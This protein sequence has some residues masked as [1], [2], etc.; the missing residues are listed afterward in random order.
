MLHRAGQVLVPELGGCTNALPDAHTGLMRQIAG[1][2]RGM[3]L[4]TLAA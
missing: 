2:R 1:R 4:T 3:N